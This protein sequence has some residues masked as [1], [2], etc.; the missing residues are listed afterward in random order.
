MKKKNR[1]NKK[2]LK[3]RLS[4]ATVIY[5]DGLGEKKKLLLE[6]YL[7]K[8]IAGIVDYYFDLLKRKK[9][10][11]FFLPP[12]INGVKITDTDMLRHENGVD[13]NV[14]APANDVN[15]Q[16]DNIDNNTNQNLNK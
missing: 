7:D 2:E 14:G 10:K 3:K 15:L 8:K 9:R 6:K 13:I 1:N 16:P 4:A 12:L 5:L 11:R